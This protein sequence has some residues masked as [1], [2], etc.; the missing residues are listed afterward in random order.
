MT[1][2]SSGHRAYAPRSPF[3]RPGAVSVLVGVT[4]SGL[5]ATLGLPAASA[6]PGGPHVAA[7]VVGTVERLHLDDFDHPLPADAD[8]ITFVRTAGGAVQ[9][10]AS[11]LARV[12]N[13]AT[14]RLGLA[15]TTG[16]R[17]TAA[18]GLTADLT[19]AQGRDPQAGANV[20]T[21]DVVS[22]PQQGQVATGTGGTVAADTAVA[23]GAA[24]HSVLVV[25]AQPPGGNATT[26]TAADVA[27]TINSGVNA[28]W[29]QV[30]GGVVGFSA[31]A[32][33]SVVQT[34]NAPCTRR[35]A[36]PPVPAGT[37][38]STSRRTP[39]AAASPASARSAAASRPAAS[40]GPTDGTASA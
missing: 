8:E 33:P 2:S 16:T 13:G 11:D 23:A 26:V 40:C 12:P 28:Y 22:E 14:V 36:G 21:V 30:T 27:A 37:S 39:G 5:L 19:R 9:V 15:D 18:G 7:T 38:S 10:P 35:A 1:S 32:Y 31:T 4:V 24:T 17:P 6:T 29:Q 3:T 34:T 25:V 20:A